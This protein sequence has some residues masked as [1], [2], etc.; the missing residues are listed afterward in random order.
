MTPEFDDQGLVGGRC[1]ACHR[2]HF[3][4]APACPWCGTDDPAP[5]RL[6]DQGTVW[7]AT[8]VTAA[9]PG[10]TGPVPYGFGVVELPADSLRIVTRFTGPVAPGDPVRYTVA[11]IDGDGDAATTTWAFTPTNP[12]A[13]PEDAR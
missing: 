6:S 5:V 10:Y 8:V 13:E 11:T 1:A 2:A 9:P 12:P 7:A 3:P 4:Q